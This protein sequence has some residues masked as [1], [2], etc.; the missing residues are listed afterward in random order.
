[1]ELKMNKLSILIFTFL[2]GFSQLAFAQGLAERRAISTYQESV[3]PTI[4]TQIN[5]AAGYELPLNVEWEK[6]ALPG[7]ADNYESDAYFTDVFFTPLVRALSSI[8]SDDLGK[9]ALAAQVKSIKITYD[10]DTA[11]SSNYADGVSFEGGEV[12]LNFK[13]FSNAGDIDDRAEAIVKVLESQ[14]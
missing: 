11:P 14:L 3:L 7:D 4:Q 12:T 9:Q 13:P 1:M 8:G 10:A 2:I 6:V 5:T